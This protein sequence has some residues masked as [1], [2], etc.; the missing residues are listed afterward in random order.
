MKLLQNN[1]L[2]RSVMLKDVV[3]AE[4]DN[5]SIYAVFEFCDHDLKGIIE[6]EDIELSLAQA[7]YYMKEILKSLKALHSKNVLHR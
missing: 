7:K 5:S 2:H 4:N 3:P 1:R 6:D